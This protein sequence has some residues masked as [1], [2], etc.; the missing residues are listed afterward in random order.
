[1]ACTLIRPMWCSEAGICAAPSRVG[2]GNTT[3]P[4]M[5]RP[6]SGAA[7]DWGKVGST[8]AEIL[9]NIDAVE[10]ATD[11]A[12]SSSAVT[13]NDVMRIHAALIA[14]VANA[15]VAGVERVTSYCKRVCSLLLTSDDV[16]LVDGIAL[17]ERTGGFGRR[18]VK[19]DSVNSVDEEA[20]ANGPPPSRGTEPAGRLARDG[21]GVHC[22]HR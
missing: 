17:T 21:L 10:L 22:E 4:G 11:H 9:A 2:G 18:V 13:L 1:M 8:A 16:R 19:G 12:T 6:G 3:L 14:T 20:Q 15:H 7:G 5:R